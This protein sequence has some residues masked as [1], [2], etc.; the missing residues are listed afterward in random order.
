M[1]LEGPAPGR[2]GIPPLPARFESIGVMLPARRLTTAE[3]MASTRHHT[4]IDLE[5][6]TGIHERHVC[7]EGEDSFTLAVGAARDCLSHS[8]HAAADMQMLVCASISHNR[9]GLHHH[10]EPPFAPAIAQAIGADRARAFDVS[11]ACAGMMT[12]VLLLRN[13]IR[14]G[15]IERGM[16]VSGEYISSLGTNAALEIR[17]VLGKQLASLTLGDAGAAAI[18][19]RAP[20]GAPSISVAGFTTLSGYSRLCLG[21]PSDVGPGASMVTQ[22][23]EIHK[24]AVADSPPLLAEVLE[25]SGLDFGQID[26]VIPHQTS[27]RAIRIGSREIAEALGVAPRNVVS[28]V[29]EFGNTASTTHFVALDKYLSE[30]R[31]KKGDKVM[32]ISF[33]SGLEVGVVIFEI[34]ELVDRHGRA[35]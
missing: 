19:E 1:L 13:F 9:G 32:L 8:R 30:G 24:V 28:N 18:V 25:E 20:D 5:R 21:K 11:N 7:S 31:F 34:D 3:L 33:A 16:V 26:H 29:A 6:L 14:R 15:V 35:D 4:H 2:T 10:L 17:S 27:A 23:R 12:G 22:A